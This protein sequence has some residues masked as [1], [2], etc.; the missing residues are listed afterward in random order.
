MK[1]RKGVLKLS[2]DELRRL[3]E[4]A[5]YN[6]GLGRGGISVVL[7]YPDGYIEQP[8]GYGDCNDYTF[9]IRATVCEI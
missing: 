7:F 5:E 3:V 8:T 2:L 1:N 4:M 6:T 9:P